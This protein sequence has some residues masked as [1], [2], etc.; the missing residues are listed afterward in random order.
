MIDNNHKKNRTTR[1]D[2]VKNSGIVGV[3]GA[4]SPI[5]KPLVTTGLAIF[6]GLEAIL[7]SNCASIV[8]NEKRPIIYPTL[9]GHK[10][11]PPKDGCFVGFHPFNENY[12][13]YYMNQI[14]KEAKI[15]TYD[16]FTSEIRRD[17]PMNYVESVSSQSSIPFVYKSLNFE[18]A[19]HGFKNLV[20]NKEFKE[21][22]TKYAKDIVNVGKPFFFCTMPELNIYSHIWGRHARTAKKV[23][24]YMWQIFEDTGANEY[25]TWVWEVYCPAGSNHDYPNF[26]YPGDKYVDWIGLSAFSRESFPTTV[27]SFNLLVEATYRAMRVSHPDK[28]VMMSEFARTQGLG[29][30]RWL[31]NAFKTI[32][33]WPG[34]KAA[35]FFNNTHISGDNHHLTAKSFEVYRE[36]MK[37][38]YFIG[39]K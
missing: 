14:G 6:A 18:V 1:R 35:I 20:D 23:W 17:F 33:S 4:T 28:S 2:F 19:Y 31:R 32:K 24:K 10:L 34:M 8:L 37:D 26:Y 7:N 38:T 21:D 3:V 29:Q 16:Y 30:D 11:Q 22:L 12:P 36:I 39:A 15:L 27:I 25:A 5:L 9:K 13:D